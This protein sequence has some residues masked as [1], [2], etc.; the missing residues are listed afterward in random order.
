MLDTWFFSLNIQP[1]TFNLKPDP[2]I[3][4]SADILTKRA[5]LTPDREALVELATGVCYT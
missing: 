1:V 5:L 3:M 4:N 2:F